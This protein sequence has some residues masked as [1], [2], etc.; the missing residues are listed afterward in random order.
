MLYK[1]LAAGTAAACCVALFW[2]MGVLLVT[3]QTDLVLLLMSLVAAVAGILAFYARKKGWRWLFFLS[4]IIVALAAG[5]GLM[6]LTD[7]LEPETASASE[8]TVL[9]AGTFFESICIRPI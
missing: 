2:I 5:L 6:A 1:G 8:Y 4:L 7:L 9:S 3:R